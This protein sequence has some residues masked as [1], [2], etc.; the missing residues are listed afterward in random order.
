MKTLKDEVLAQR[1][2][3][4]KLQTQIQAQVCLPQSPAVHEASTPGLPG[5]QSDWYL[6]WLTFGSVFAAISPEAWAYASKEPWVQIVAGLFT[7]WVTL[8][9]ILNFPWPLF[10]LQ[11][12]KIT[13]ALLGLYQGLRDK[14]SPPL[15]RNITPH[16]FPASPNRLVCC[17][18][19]SPILF[20][21]FFS[22]SSILQG[23]RYAANFIE[24][25]DFLFPNSCFFTF[26]LA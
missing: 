19:F 5:V 22:K 12:G 8:G 16:P 13:T 23:R 7:S 1:Y 24:E 15:L 14:E 26:F 6:T 25:W 17:E 11:N 10:L 18:H 2:R 20:G 21:L 4:I 9:K 3:G